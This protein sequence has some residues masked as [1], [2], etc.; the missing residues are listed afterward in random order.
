MFFCILA[1]ETCKNLT[2]PI[3]P[4][5]SD[6]EKRDLFSFFNGITPINQDLFALILSIL[7]KADYNKGDIILKE[8]EICTRSHIVLS[9]V[10][11]QFKY[12][13]GEPVTINITPRGNAFNTLK[14]VMFQ[15]PSD[16]VHEAIT[17]VTLVYF[18]QAEIDSLALKNHAFCYALYKIH[19]Y[20]LLDRENRMYMLQFRQPAKRYRLFREDILRAQW[21]LLD[22]PDKIVASYLNMTP[23]QYSREKKAWLNTEAQ[24]D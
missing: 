2:H 6:D 10:V 12:D 18:E 14:S 17:N 1:L 5:L 4:N 9:G 13:D 3:M 21:I 16:E 24:T 22:T 15:S 7:H 20:I 8:G 11:H 23:Q 19:E